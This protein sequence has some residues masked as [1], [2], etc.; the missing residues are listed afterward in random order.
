[1]RFLGINA[2]F[3]DPAAALVVDGEVIA[4]AE[5]ERFSRRKH[6]KR[7]VPFSAWELPE[8]AAAWCLEQAGLRPEDLD[9]VA[10][11]YDPE[12]VVPGGPGQD[13]H[14]EDLRTAYARRAPTFLATALPG[15]DAAQV[16]FVPHHIAHAASA[17]LAAPHRESAVLVCDGRGEAVS[18]L[19][20]HYRDGE[21]TVL[22]SQA[23]PHSL[24]LMYE[25]L[26]QHLGFLRSSDEYKVMALASYGEPRF[27]REMRDL[28]YATGDGGFRVE[29]IDWSV[30]AKALGK[31]EK[32]TA[33]HADLAASVQIRLEE[34]LLDLARWLHERTGDRCLTMAGG[35]ALNCVANTRLFAEG[36][37]EE[38]WVQ[39]AAGDSGTALGG[40]LHLA[41][42]GGDPVRPMPGAD[43]GRSWTDEELGAWLD[44]ARVPYE[45]PADL[46]AT[47]AAEL[48]ADRVIAWFQGRA[49][50]G[51][52]ALGRRSLLAHPG[53]PRNTERLND[54][55]GRE[56]FRPIAPMVLAERASMIF[57]RGPVP[58]PH[59]LF[60]HDVRPEWR[61]RIPAVVH[62]DGTA[63]IQTVER[64]RDPLLARLL[65]EFEARTGLPVVV[66]TSLNTAGRPM[67]DD[68]R[69]ALECFGSAPV[70]V[71]VLGPYV[72]RRGAV[73]A[74]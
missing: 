69:D 43:L 2:I 54:V 48:A 66:N 15:L 61:D 74:G 49:E 33:D 37:F 38:V 30:Y 53:N 6:G 65:E 67:A 24:G 45:R 59:M 64:G 20:G 63:R 7:P 26:T 21:L 28:I 52:R 17:G 10:Y 18:H 40:A 51:P 41:Q 68:P 22:A 11:S 5:E 35:V 4:A 14:W 58:S 27:L 42:A 55:K 57:G 25:D 44:V 62:V 71:L 36:P 1:M 23:L 12:L 34:V 73:F 32:W 9:G 50:Y 60:V 13:G 47:V 70:D 72:V 31:G 46:A 16:R 29:R 19:A 56:Q 39:P 3:H 8:L